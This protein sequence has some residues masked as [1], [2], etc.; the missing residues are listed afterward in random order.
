MPDGEIFTGP[1]EDSVSGRVF[2]SYSS[3]SDGVEVEGVE[4]TFEE[5]KV[6]KATAAKNEAYLNQKLD[7]DDGSRFL[8]EFA[9][10]LNYG[11]TQHTKNILFDEK[12]GGSI[13]MALGAGYPGTGSTNESAIHW[14][15]VTD[16]RDDAEIEVD[17]EIVYENGEFT[18]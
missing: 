10:G 7:T 5:G 11:V 16:M 8:G 3:V 14:D 17:G 12:I 18:I 13:H 15:F 1:V 2:F 4:L 9:I 6:V